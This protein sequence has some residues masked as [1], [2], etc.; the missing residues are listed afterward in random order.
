MFLFFCLFAIQ[1]FDYVT[2]LALLYSN[3][4]NF[5]RYSPQ[6]WSYFFAPQQNDCALSFHSVRYRSSTQKDNLEAKNKPVFVTFAAD[7][8]WPCVLHPGGYS[9][10]VQHRG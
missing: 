1:T 10:T 4:I 5:R 6:F 7:R 3:Y 9:F 2:S 8:F